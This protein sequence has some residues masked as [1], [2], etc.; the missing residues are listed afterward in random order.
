[1]SDERIEIAEAE[2]TEL[3]EEA[4]W[5]DAPDVAEAEVDTEADYLARIGELEEKLRLAEEQHAERER[6]L[7][8]MAL[9]GAAGLPAELKDAVMVSADMH[10]TVDLI[11]RTVAQ[12]V[13][14]EVSRRCRTDAPLTGS[15]APL[16]RDELLRMPIAELQRLRD[17]GFTL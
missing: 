6:E 2:E 10:G 4:D 3:P 14:A 11:M 16:T 9:L 15:R 13:D 17:S 1:M 7:E 12:R 8:C 5:A